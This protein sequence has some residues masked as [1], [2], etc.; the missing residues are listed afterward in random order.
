MRESYN[1]EMSAKL[2]DFIANWRKEHPDHPAD[3]PLP[4]D[5]GVEAE[6]EKFEQAAD[7]AYASQ[8]LDLNNPQHVLRSS[9]MGDL[10]YTS[11]IVQN[12]VEDVKFSHAVDASAKSQDISFLCKSETDA[13]AILA[14][15][16]N[17]DVARQLC[18]AKLGSVGIVS[19]S[20][21]GSNLAAAVLSAAGN[22]AAVGNGEGVEGNGGAAAGG[23]EGNN[24]AAVSF[25]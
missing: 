11:E 24:S 20:A 7:A 1:L 13:S 6:K 8:V 2:D 18:T 14:L 22:G 9:G 21:A 19:A 17:S 10:L 23:A 15:L 25:Q 16:Q 12:G 3:D 4:E 5:A